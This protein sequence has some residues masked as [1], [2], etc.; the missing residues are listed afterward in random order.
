MH[1]TTT[2]LADRVRAAALVALVLASRLAR[3]RPAA[4]GVYKVY[5]LNEAPEPGATVREL[6]ARD[7]DPAAWLAQAARAAPEF[8]SLRVE[9]RYVYRGA[10]YR[11]V[12]RPGDDAEAVLPPGAAGAG[13]GLLAPPRV[14]SARLQGPP[15]SDDVDRDVTARVRKYQ[16]PAR[17]FHGWGVRL[18]DMFPF[19]DHDDDARVYSHLRIVDA[20]ARVTDLDYAS[21]PRVGLV[22]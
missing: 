12:L 13:G 16:G 3:P 14:V 4:E 17:D 1:V 8:E 11:A 15:G 18:H 5:V 10:K 19:E 21:N 2:S 9:V 6:S 20:R 22:T 7:F